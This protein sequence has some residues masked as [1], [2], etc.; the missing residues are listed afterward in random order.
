MFNVFFP[1]IACAQSKSNKMGM[2]IPRGES[3]KYF[4]WMDKDDKGFVDLLDWNELI[5]DHRKFADIFVVPDAEVS[6]I[7]GERASE[8]H[9]SGGNF[10]HVIFKGCSQSF[11]TSGWL[12]L[13]HLKLKSH[14][15]QR[16][17]WFE[18]V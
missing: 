16:K 15:V 9:A 12:L 1:S 14:P 13:L 5:S 6:T 17:D 18:S 11:Q 8:K 3:K 2:M 10:V 4:T 7:S